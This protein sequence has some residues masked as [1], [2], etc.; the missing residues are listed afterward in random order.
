MNSRTLGETSSVAAL[1][2]DGIRFGLCGQT[3]EFVQVAATA[4]PTFMAPGTAKGI[5]EPCERLQRAHHRP[6]SSGHRAPFDKL[7]N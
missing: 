5:T 2:S 3:K 6:L 4:R 1:W 7:N